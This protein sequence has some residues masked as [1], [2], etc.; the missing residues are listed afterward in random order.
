M[1]YST[2]CECGHQSHINVRNQD[3]AVKEMIPLTKKHMETAH[4]GIPVNEEDIKNTM[5]SRVKQTGM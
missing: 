2:T 1:K 5:P 3:E 4:P